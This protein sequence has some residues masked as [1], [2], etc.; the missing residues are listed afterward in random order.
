MEGE[1]KNKQTEVSSILVLR[2]PHKDIGRAAGAKKQ[3]STHDFH[4]NHQQ[5]HPQQPQ[6]RS[7]TY[8]FL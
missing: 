1:D 5:H 8:S 3:P 4:A 2:C 6:K 7:P